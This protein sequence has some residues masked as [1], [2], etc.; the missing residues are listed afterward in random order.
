MDILVANSKCSGQVESLS[1]KVLEEKYPTTYYP[2]DSSSGS[3]WNLLA[4]YLKKNLDQLR[5]LLNGSIWK[6]QTVIRD[7]LY[8]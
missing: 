4:I 5:N 7:E 6:G 1:Y 8:S 3:S 2:E